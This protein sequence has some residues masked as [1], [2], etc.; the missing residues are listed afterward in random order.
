M[1]TRYQKQAVKK[2]ILQDLEGILK[3]YEQK[4]SQV[5]TKKRRNMIKKKA[6]EV[7]FTKWL[8]M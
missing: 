8:E 4:I 1:Y 5:K 6:Q 3:T 7:I 2:Y